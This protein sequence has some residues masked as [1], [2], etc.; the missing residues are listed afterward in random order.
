MIAQL[1]AFLSSPLFGEIADRKG[2]LCLMNLL[3]ACVII[4]NIMLTVAVVSGVDELTFPAF[5]LTNVYAVSA[6]GSMTVKT[7]LV[8]E[9]RTRIR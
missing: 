9:G 8:F 1:I 7:G 3:A 4:G 5:I 2:P 6:G